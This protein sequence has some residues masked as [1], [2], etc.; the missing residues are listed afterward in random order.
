[1]FVPRDA[2][3][4][5]QR[6]PISFEYLYNQCCNDVVQ[7]RFSPELKYEI[8]L[9]LSALQLHQHAMSSNGMQ[10]ANGKVNLKV[11]E[12]ECGLESFVPFSLLESM[13]RKELHKLLNHFL[14]H[15][16]QQLC[17]TGQKAMTAIQAKLHYLKIISELPSYG[18]KMFSINIKDSSPESGLLVSP[19]FGISHVNSMRN[20]L[21]ISLAR[22]EDI[23]YIKVTK[24]D[25][26]SYCI[27]VQL[28]NA[29]EM[30]N[31]SMESPLHFMLEDR[32][33]EEFVLILKGYHRLFNKYEINSNDKELPVFWD[34]SEEWWNDSGMCYYFY[35]RKLA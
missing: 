14:K 18:A 7:E 29:K 32:E 27:E 6:D 4:L 35:Y 31:T 17:P 16:H 5:L 15:N 19:K 2:Y 23:C 21:P 12:R 20:S 10:S 28:R 30:T 11:I 1:M 25:E 22:I 33:A 34:I 8:A 9:R 24:D 13:K 3:D 26:L